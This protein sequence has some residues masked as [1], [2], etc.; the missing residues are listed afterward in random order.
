MKA[1]QRVLAAGAF[2][3]LAAV[4]RRVWGA[5]ASDRRS[6]WRDGLVA[7]FSE[8]VKAA[9]EQFARDGETGAVAAESRGGLEVVVVVGA[10]RA[11]A[12]IARLRTAP[13]AARLVLG[14]RV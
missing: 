12:R 1:V 13:S 10:T 6:G 14:E 7:E 2:R 4:H 5:R 8:R 9:L 11:G 3:E